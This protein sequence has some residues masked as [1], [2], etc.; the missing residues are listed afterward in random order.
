MKIRASEP[1]YVI[2]E[3]AFSDIEISTIFDALITM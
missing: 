3:S 1:K 2:R